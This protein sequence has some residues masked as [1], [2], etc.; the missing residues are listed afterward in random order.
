MS[1]KGLW[2]A[3]LI[4]GGL[5][6]VGC[7]GALLS[8]SLPTGAHRKGAMEK[9]DQRWAALVEGLPAEGEAMPAATL[10]DK[11]EG[12][13]RVWPLHQE[14]LYNRALLARYGGE[15]A[16]ALRLMGRY[17]T[18]ASGRPISKGSPLQSVEGGVVYPSLPVGGG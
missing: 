14:A 9:A 15:Q 17:H 18:G 10:R 4:V 3:G 16:E 2:I 12:V 6:G 13:L 11:L 8:P 7:A 5:F 1:N